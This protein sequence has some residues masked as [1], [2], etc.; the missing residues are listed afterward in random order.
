MKQVF[1]EEEL[2]K[3]FDRAKEMHEEVRKA[4]AIQTDLSNPQSVLG[5]L[6]AIVNVQSTA[7]TSKAMFTYLL[8]KHTGKKVTALKDETLNA[9]EKKAILSSEI[10]DVLF[11]DNLSE[12][13]L[14]QMY[15]RMEALRSALSYLKSEMNNLN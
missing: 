2:Q 13:L 14:K 6:Q 1:Q 11:Y 7:A 15:Y 12:L 5:A 10:G 4:V 9:H 3:R 8:D